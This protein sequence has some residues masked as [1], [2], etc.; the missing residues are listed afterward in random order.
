MGKEKH[1]YLC[2]FSGVQTPGFSPTARS[3]KTLDPEKKTLERDL[4]KSFGRK[5][6]SLAKFMK[7][8]NLMEICW[9]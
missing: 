9:M 1:I 7:I 3:K 4:Q 2:D 5:L 8:Q 6:Q